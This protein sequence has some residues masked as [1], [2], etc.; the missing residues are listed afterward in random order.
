MSCP[1]PQP[2]AQPCDPSMARGPAD[3]DWWVVGRYDKSYLINI[4]SMHMVVLL[5]FNEVS[6]LGYAEIAEATSIPAADL[7]R[8]LQS[9]ACGHYKLLVKE[10]KGKEVADSDKF[11]FNSKFTNKMI[12]FKVA[13]IAAAKETNEEV[14]ASRNKMNEDRNPQIDAAIVRVMKSRRVM[15]HNNLIA[16]VTKQL[17]S[18][19][20]PN[21]VVLKKR[22]EGLI[23]RDFLQRQRGNIKTYE[24]LA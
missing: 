12:K 4:P 10:P 9:L 21:P 8:V 7:K 6:T 16:E 11:S 17:Q 3:A 14:L 13:S 1:L 20:S 22:I 5:L 18:R 2:L 23:D 19:F 15:D 24:Y